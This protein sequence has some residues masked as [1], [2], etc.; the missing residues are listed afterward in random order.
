MSYSLCVSLSY[1]IYAAKSSATPFLPGNRAGFLAVYSGFF[2]ANN[3]LRPARLAV[4]TYFAPSLEAFIRSLQSRLRLPRAAATALT[5]LCFNVCGTFA[6]M[7]VGI[8]I[9]ALA[10]GVPPSWGLLLGGGP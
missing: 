4:A 6:A 2:V 5:V 3:F 7:F 9:A 10:S 1:Y 8:Q